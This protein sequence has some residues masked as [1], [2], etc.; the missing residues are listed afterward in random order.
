MKKPRS[1]VSHLLPAQEGIEIL[2]S[3]S[4]RIGSVERWMGHGLVAESVVEG[5]ARAESAG[6]VDAAEET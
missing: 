6:T 3:G 2:H 5:Q 4:V 1:R